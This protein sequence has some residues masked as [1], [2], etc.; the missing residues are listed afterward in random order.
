MHLQNYLSERVGFSG[1]SFP[2]NISQIKVFY[3]QRSLAE[4]SRRPVLL[5]PC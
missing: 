4:A 1:V 2:T 5:V 3:G